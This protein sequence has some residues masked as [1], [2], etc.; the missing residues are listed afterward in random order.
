M[1][2]DEIRAKEIVRAIN[3]AR[4]FLS[5]E[6]FYDEL[7]NKLKAHKCPYTHTVIPQMIACGVIQKSG[8]YYKFTSQKPVCWTRMLD[9]AIKVAKSR[10]QVNK[11][12]LTKNSSNDLDKYIQILKDA[13]YKVMKPVQCIQYEEL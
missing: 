8:K 3:E 4:L 2:S 7:L 10:K 13:G 12:F 11:K 5:V 6:F 1:Q 9:G